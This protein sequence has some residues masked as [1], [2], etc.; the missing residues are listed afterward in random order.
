MI[1]ARAHYPEP[2]TFAAP[3]G[4]AVH[5]PPQA[6]DAAARVAALV[7][8]P[9]RPVERGS[10]WWVVAGAAA[11]PVLRAP[12]RP[13]GFALAV[14]SDR[15]EIAGRGRSALGYAAAS[16][17]GGGLGCRR[18]VDFADLA[19]RGV[20]LDLKGPTLA[21]SYVD[22]LLARLGKLRF[23][24]LL[25]EYEDKFPYPAE[26]DL[27][28]A[29]PVDVPALLAAADGHGMTVVP[30]VQCLGH[31]EYALR[32]PRWRELAEDPRHQQLCP[33]LPGSLEFFAAALDAVLAAHPG[34]DLVH[35]GGDEPWSLGRCARC[36]RVPRPDLYAGYVSAAARLVVEAG[37]RP[38]IWDDMLY[39]ERDPG[40][41]D[42]LPPETV[43]MAWEYAATGR[44]GWARWGNPQTIVATSDLVAS[45]PSGGALVP[46]GAP[47]V[48]LASLPPD[49][50]ALIEAVKSGDH[51]LPWVRALVARGRTVLGAAAVRGAD[52]ENLA[53]PRWSR[54]LANVAMWASHARSL[55][56]DGVVSTAWA[57][58]DTVSPPTEPLPTADPLLA[59]SAALYWNAD[60]SVTLP[61]WCHVVEHGTVQDLRTL[62]ASA[63]DP[64]VRACARHRLLSIATDE[65]AM[66]ASWHRVAA[67]EDPAV[68]AARVAATASVDRLLD[69]W[70]DWQREY[71]AAVREVYAGDG[72]DVVA[73]AKA[74]EAIRRLTG[75]R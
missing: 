19:V 28:A 45:A 12:D 60:A 52:A 23:N 26:L 49:E 36:A 48:P 63:A 64:L 44:T 35:I 6:A 15:I 72:A 56:I 51:P 38:V 21:P 17:A 58:Y 75:L 5:H 70:R 40:M 8:L 4:A 25:V 67:G 10:G 16:L 29:D 73:S 11:G 41:V 54:R 32:R 71:A 39:A 37:R 55:G 34:A 61:D 20:H 74:A 53:Y 33:L 42:T 68:A 1:P 69:E 46:P 31:L 9:T 30:L 62:S 66:T 14:T 13:D 59:A 47:L 3:A 27:A 18:E 43:V 50:Q 2:G 57:A 24:T 7:G 65:V 22:D